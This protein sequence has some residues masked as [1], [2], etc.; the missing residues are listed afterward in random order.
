MART[1][2]V[3]TAT[4]WGTQGAQMEKTMSP[5]ELMVAAGLDWDPIKVP[6]FSRDK[7]GEEYPMKHGRTH[8]LHRDDTMEVMDQ[9][10]NDW[11]PVSNR[12]A[13]DFFEDFCRDGKIK[14]DIAGFVRGY[15][16]I[17]ARVEND[18]FEVTKGDLIKA[19]LLFTVPHIYGKTTN[20]QFTPIRMFCTNQLALIAKNRGDQAI[21][22]NHRRKFDP[23]AAK[24]IVKQSHEVMMEYK[25]NAKFL[26]SKKAK[27][28][29]MVEYFRR[30]FPSGSTKED[31]VVPK[32][33]PEV[34]AAKQRNAK[35]HYVKKLE[36]ATPAQIKHVAEVKTSGN[37]KAAIG[38]LETQP[39]ADHGA[40]TWWAPFNAVT[41]M[42]D[43]QVGK[44]PE[45]R[46]LNSW[47]G[48]NRMKKVE[49]L[50]KALEFA[51]AA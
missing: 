7:D 2:A 10:S 8:A 27:K 42:L 32:H 39:G 40:G 20:I 26:A 13:F 12:I 9:V 25:A 34:Q 51:K 33:E 29:D 44:D 14:M 28:E 17:T 49:A 19:N 30:M 4:P 5:R 1:A 15:A 6:L 23:E 3:T 24:R 46:H 18:D 43:H 11:E 50:N 41:Y 35:G 37:A 21:K 16:W 45:V 31:V 48:S 22:I 47:Y 38:F 36:V